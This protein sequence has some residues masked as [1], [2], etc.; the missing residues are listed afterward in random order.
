[1]R[2]ETYLSSTVHLDTVARSHHDK[3]DGADGDHEDISFGTTPDVDNLGDRQL[4]HRTDDTGN[5]LGS[6]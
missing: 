3:A 1:M 2:E 4:G 6:S 5:D